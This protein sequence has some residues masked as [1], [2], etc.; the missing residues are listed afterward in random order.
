MCGGFFS[1]GGHKMSLND[2]SN[3]FQLMQLNVQGLTRGKFLEFELFLDEHLS[4]DLL[5][6]SEH[7]LS[8]DECESFRHNAW[9]VASFFARSNKIRGGSL[10]L[11][12]D[13]EYEVVQEVNDL[14]TECIC[15]I[16]ALKRRN[17]TVLNVYRPPKGNFDDFLNG[18]KIIKITFHKA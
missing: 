14:S 5:C 4:Y 3:V 17:I 18:Q 9:H 16:S 8:A 13:Q 15:E 7:W 2:T 10:I 12:K 11:C 6:L 1:E